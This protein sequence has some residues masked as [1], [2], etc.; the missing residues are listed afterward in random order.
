MSK[1]ADELKETFLH[2][3]QVVF[4]F[5]IKYLFHSMTCESVYSFYVMCIFY[6]FLVDIMSLLIKISYHK[7][8]A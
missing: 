1:P 8:S 3:V 6:Y 5:K 7:I 4:C 2:Q